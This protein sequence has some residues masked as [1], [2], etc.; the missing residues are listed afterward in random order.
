MTNGLPFRI[1]RV[2][3]SGL[4]SLDGR[5]CEVET[6]VWLVGDDDR[7]L[8]IDA[9]HDPGAILAGI[10]GRKVEG[11]LCTHGHNDHVNAAVDLASATGAPVGL[12]PADEVLWD[13]VH[14]GRRPDMALAHG[15]VIERA[16]AQLQVWHTPGH[17]PGGVC[18]HL[19]EAG[20]VFTGDTLFQGGPGA[21]GPPL[22]IVSR[23]HFPTLIESVRRLLLVMP[24]ATTV[25][26]GHGESTSVAEEA[27]HVEEWVARGR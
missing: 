1:D 25:H 5:S 18:F 12:H 9:A 21:S 20:V 13:Q 22:D 14:P 26:A 7:V 27:P 10:G 19:A 16:G 23:S 2:V 17:S 8:V 6:N 15:D 11:I 3:T 24:P 4:F